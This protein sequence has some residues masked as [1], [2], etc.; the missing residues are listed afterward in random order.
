MDL[1]EYLQFGCNLTYLSDLTNPN[2]NINAWKYVINS[3][4]PEQFSLKDWNE[5]VHYLCREDIQLHT[6]REAKDYLLNYN[7]QKTARCV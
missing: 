4:V 1:L 7:P 2:M 5:A 3:I 6:A